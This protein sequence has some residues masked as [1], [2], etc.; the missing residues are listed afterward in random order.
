M[1]TKSK[2]YKEL[3]DGTLDLSMQNISKFPSK[4]ILPIADRIR[5]LDLSRNKFLSL[6]ADIGALINLV[7]LDLSQNSLME[8]PNEISHLVKLR[9]LILDG[10]ALTNLPEDFIELKRLQ[11]LDLR[12]NPLSPHLQDAAGD[13]QTARECGIAAIRVLKFQKVYKDAVLIK[14][15]KDEAKRLKEEVKMKQQLK[16]AKMIEKEKRRNAWEQETLRKELEAD[17]FGTNDGDLKENDTDEE[18]ILSKANDMSKKEINTANKTSWTWI[19]CAIVMV[20]LA[21]YVQF[22]Q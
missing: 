16:Q 13:C 22:S 9:K 11:Y 1:A 18:I 20:F 17:I 3:E 2:Y 14:K 7:E 4:D 19:I 5:R 12:G 8:L 6:P 15:A 21:I 10:N